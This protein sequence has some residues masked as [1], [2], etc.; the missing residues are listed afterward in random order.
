M[1]DT[2]NPSDFV[3][4]TLFP[5]H[6]PRTAGRSYCSQDRDW[7]IPG[8]GNRSDGEALSPSILR[9][10]IPL[11]S[12]TTRTLNPF[13]WDGMWGLSY[14]AEE[15]QIKMVGE[16]ER[17]AQ[18]QGN[19]RFWRVGGLSPGLIWRDFQPSRVL[20]DDNTCPAW[21]QRKVR[22]FHS[23]CKSKQGQ[24]CQARGEAR[25]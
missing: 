15:T 13:S 18:E 2:G 10:P 12:L 17:E 1:D 22:G 3:K 24:T 4:V 16:K 21:G 7:D 8:A 6:H 14:F 19:G 25:V 20:A 5:V 23:G 11:H 9:Y